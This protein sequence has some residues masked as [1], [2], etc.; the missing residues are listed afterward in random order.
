MARLELLKSPLQGDAHRK[1][2]DAY[3][4]ISEVAGDLEVPQ[5]VLRFWETHFPQVKPSRMRGSRRYYRPEDIELL[6]KIK[7]LL[8]SQGYT[9]KGAKKLIR[10][11]KLAADSVDPAAAATPRPAAQTPQKKSTKPDV[12][13]LVS[14]LRILKTMLAALV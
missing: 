7:I 14:E 8:Y 6:K 4:T 11:G 5:H 1:S 9:I 12:R 2:D 10:E 3:K 13:F